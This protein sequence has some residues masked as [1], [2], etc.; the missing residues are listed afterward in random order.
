MRTAGWPPAAQVFSSATP[1][2]SV[3]G[4]WLASGGMRLPRGGMGW[5]GGMGG[6][7]RRK[8]AMR[9]PACKMGSA[10]FMLAAA[11]ACPAGHSSP[12]YLSTYRLPRQRESAERLGRGVQLGRLPTSGI[13]FLFSAG[14]SGWIPQ[15][16]L[17]G[18]KLPPQIFWYGGSELLSQGRCG[19]HFFCHAT[20]FQSAVKVC[21]I[22]PCALPCFSASA[23]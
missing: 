1:T 22:G 14:C 9:T 19:R 10:A 21:E 3:P 18:I 12:T 6:P 23:E 11:C 7:M 20:F 13:S 4:G 17:W 8:V 16:L 5:A 2:T 15:R